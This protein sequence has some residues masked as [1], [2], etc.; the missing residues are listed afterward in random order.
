MCGFLF[1]GTVPLLMDRTVVALLAC[2]TLA[3]CSGVT[4]VGGPTE[5]VTPAPVA[6]PP[7]TPAP[8][9][10]LPPGVTGSG[11]ENVDELVD[12]HRD[13]LV[14]RSYAWHDRYVRNGS[15]PDGGDDLDVSHLLHVENETTF[16]YAT[17]HRTVWRDG[18][19]RHLGN[20]TEYADPTGQ[21]VRVENIDS[22]TQYRRSQR[23]ADGST[24]SD[25]P[26]AAV[27]RFLDVRDGSVTLTR[28][29]GRRYYRIRGENPTFVTAQPIHNYTVTALVRP[30]GLVRTLTV[31]YSIGRPGR[32]ETVRY[33]FEY[34]RVGT[35]TVDRPAWVT[36]QWGEDD[37]SSDTGQDRE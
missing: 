6:T 30:D 32:L 29:D 36:A 33:H 22:G 14:N 21:Y 25:R 7:P 5:T 26:A 4:G 12:A 10:T 17:N 9:E 34:Q 8:M 31:S 35:T 24:G 19:Q 16:L 3:G 20:Y 18:R 1:F 28:S 15:N 27:D 11:V 37:G 2:V 23:I 13:A